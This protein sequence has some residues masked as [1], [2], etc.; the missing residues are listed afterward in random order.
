MFSTECSQ[1]DGEELPGCGGPG[2]GHVIDFRPAAGD[3][4]SLAKPLLYAIGRIGKL[5]LSC[6]LKWQHSGVLTAVDGTKVGRLGPRWW[7]ATM[8]I[9]A[10]VWSAQSFQQ[11]PVALAAQTISPGSMVT[12]PPGEAGRPLDWAGKRIGSTGHG[13][14]PVR[15]SCLAAASPAGSRRIEWPTARRARSQPRPG[16]TEW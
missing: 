9:K 1:A 2:D 11:Q 4:H 13:F 12:S 6:C 16:P 8:Q 7:T 5:F 15:D 14:F 10:R 3:D